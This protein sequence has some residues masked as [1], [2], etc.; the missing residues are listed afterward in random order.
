MK[1]WLC[2]ILAAVLLVGLVPAAAAKAPDPFGSMKG[3]LTTNPQVSVKNSI[4]DAAISFSEVETPRECTL[5]WYLDD[6]LVAEDPHFL[7]EEGSGASMQTS[8]HFGDRTGDAVAL[9]VELRDNADHQAVTRF[10]RR[11]FVRDF[12]Q[13]EEWPA[14]DEYEIHVIRNQCVVVVYRKDA[15][16]NYTEIANA[17]V[18]SPGVGDTTVTG[19]FGAYERDDWDRV[20]DSHTAQYPI[21]IHGDWQFHSVPYYTP[22]KDSLNLEAY[23]QLGQKASAGPIRLAVADV[24]WIHDHCPYGTRVRLYDSDLAAVVKPVPIRLTPDTFQGWDPTDPDPH[25]PNRARYY[26]SFRTELR[27]AGNNATMLSGS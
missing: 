22:K 4:V 2:A 5:R 23:N 10:T 9:W 25:N 26:P 24:K 17:F 27:P 16:W 12:E 6:M 11:I 1:R 8:V 19:T 3:V 13:P 18:C 15:D 14:K 21:Q 20:V 7:L